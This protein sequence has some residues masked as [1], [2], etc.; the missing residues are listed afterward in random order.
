MSQQALPRREFD[1]SELILRLDMTFEADVQRMVLV[2]DRVMEVARGMSCIQGKEFEVEICL[3]EAL[4][5]AIVHGCKGDPAKK[6]QLTVCCDESR[7]MLLIVRDPGPGFAVDEIRS[8]L[9]GDNI[10][11]AH[12]RGIFLINQ[13]MDEVRFLGRGTEI[14]MVKR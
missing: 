7:G 2:V 10:F 1:K 14:H 6:V 12:G 11:A 13:L 8:P 3:R 5:N 4:V 9:V